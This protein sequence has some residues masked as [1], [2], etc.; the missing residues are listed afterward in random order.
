MLDRVKEHIK[1]KGFQVAPAELEELLLT[2]LEIVD[3]AVRV[4][5]DDGSVLP[6]AI[7]AS[8]AALVDAGIP[9]K[10]LAVLLCCCLTESENI[11]LDPSKLEEQ[12]PITMLEEND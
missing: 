4:V 10:Y 7:H 11:T 9:L 8:C 12:I 5:H 2:H 6:C 1:H 3:D